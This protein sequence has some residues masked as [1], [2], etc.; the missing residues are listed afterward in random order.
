MK[1][2]AHLPVFGAELGDHLRKLLCPGGVQRQSSLGT[3]QGDRRRSG[4]RATSYF[5]QRERFQHTQAVGV[6]FHQMDPPM[7]DSN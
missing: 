2:I 3:F 7:G 1:L 6:P 5:G 4:G